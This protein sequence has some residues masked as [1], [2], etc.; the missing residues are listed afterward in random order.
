VEDSEIIRE[1]LIESSENLARLEREI[2]E[3]EQRPKD[4]ALLASIFRTIHSIKGTC[5]FLAFS[6]LERVAHIAENILSQL[7]NGDRDL[8][9][10]LASLILETMDVIKQ[11]LAS[12][13]ATL[14][15]SG[16]THEDLCRR[17]TLMESEVRNRTAGTPPRPSATVSPEPSPA[18]SDAMNREG[19]PAVA[20]PAAAESAGISDTEKSLASKTSSIADGTIRVDVGLLDKLMNLVGELVLARNQ[21]L[22]YTSQQD[23]ANF[24]SAS[25]RPRGHKQH[26]EN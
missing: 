5:G 1:F 22:Q 17:L 8:T 24:L 14:K 13:E 20:S 26:L 16:E 21:I 11:E 10:A 18:P 6:N 25:R 12:I 3:L 9:P 2:V 4:P 23:D 19:V 7:R 15:E